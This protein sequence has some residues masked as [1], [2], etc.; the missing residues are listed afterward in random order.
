MKNNN[1]SIKGGTHETILILYQWGY[2]GTMIK[3]QLKNRK[4]KNI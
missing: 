4:L 3:K 1:Y 2:T